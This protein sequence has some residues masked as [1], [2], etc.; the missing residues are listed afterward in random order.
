MWDPDVGEREEG[1]GVGLVRG[2]LGRVVPG[3]GPSG[4]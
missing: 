1:L 3:C 4:Y 2:D